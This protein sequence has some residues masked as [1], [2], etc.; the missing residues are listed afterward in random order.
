MLQMM[1]DNLKPVIYAEDTPLFQ[2]GDPIRSM[3]LI[4]E[5]TL[6]I[7]RTT[8][9]DSCVAS[10]N[11]KRGSISSSPSG[12]NLGKGDFYG[13]EELI[14]WVTQDKDFGQLPSSAFSV[15]C[16]SK[17]EGFVLTAKDL[18]SVVAKCENWWKVG[19]SKSDQNKC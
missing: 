19:I 11:A 5:G 13:A 9:N 17:V 6:F 16:D 15:K 1:C 4:T 14:E 12:S 3:L 10:E 8:S 7:H 18:K 2:I